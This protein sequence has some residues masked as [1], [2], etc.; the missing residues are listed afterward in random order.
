MNTEKCG[1]FEPQRAQRT[2]R[3]AN[4]IVLWVECGRGDGCGERV[5]KPGGTLN[6]GRRGSA[7]KNANEVTDGDGGGGGRDF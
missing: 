1:E 5:G 2:Q 4:L 6:H 7:R 3:N